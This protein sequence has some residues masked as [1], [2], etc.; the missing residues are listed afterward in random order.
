LS[1]AQPQ[2][3]IL[4]QPGLYVAEAGRDLASTLAGRFSRITK[5]AEISRYRHGKQ[6]QAYV[7]YRLEGPTAPIL[8]AATSAHDRDR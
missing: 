1:F 5:F 2:P 8:D 4:S 7:L 3:N 6:I